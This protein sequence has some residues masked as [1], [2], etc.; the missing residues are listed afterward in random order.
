MKKRFILGA[1]AV[2]ALAS[3]GVVA[4]DALKSGLPVGGSPTP[5]NPL[6]VTGPFEGKKQCL[7]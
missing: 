2:M 7:V 5:F 1:F 4:G 3:A 6:S